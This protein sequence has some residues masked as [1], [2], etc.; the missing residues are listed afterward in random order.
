MR[1]TLEQYLSAIGKQSLLTPGEEKALAEAAQNG[2]ESA[3]RKLIEANLRLVVGIAKYYARTGVSLSDLIQD[4]NLGL[5]RAADTFDASRNCRFSTY[6]TPWIKQAIRHGLDSGVAAIR[7][8]R[9]MSEIASKIEELTSLHESL[10]G[11]KPTVEEL[12]EITGIPASK[13][14]SA[15]D[16]RRAPISLYERTKEDSGSRVE[17]LIPDPNAGDPQAEVIK[18]ER[19]RLVEDFLKTLDPKEAFIIKSHFGLGSHRKRSLRAIAADLNITYEWVRKTEMRVLRRFR[20]ALM[21]QNI[22]DL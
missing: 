17:D 20:A 7:L 16:S 18:N 11:K 6:A 15:I 2:D 3:K 8:P 14:R 9:Y 12:S 10:Y 5:I 21:S 19:H 13:I 4:G 22:A 1:S